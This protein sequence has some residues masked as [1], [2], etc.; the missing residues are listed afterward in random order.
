M[1]A[2]KKLF[3]DMG[4][5][6]EIL[7]DGCCGMAGSFG[8][9]EHK[10]DVSMKIYEHEL[11]PRVQKMPPDAV[12]VADGF[13]CRTQIEQAG[14][15]RPLHLAQFLRQAM[16]RS[17]GIEDMELARRDAAATSARATAGLVALGV[18]IGIGAWL[19]GRRLSR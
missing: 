17:P 16:G 12:M 5:K 1:D 11:G 7:D 3:A 8:F 15:K 4:V 19:L 18:G 9:E 2:E 14:G 10:Y 13:S 6:A